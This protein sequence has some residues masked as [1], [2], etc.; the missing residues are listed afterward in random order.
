MEGFSVYPNPV[1]GV[2][3]ERKSSCNGSNQI[4]SPPRTIQIQFEIQMQILN[5]N[6]NSNT[7]LDTKR[8]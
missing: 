8:L 5:E 4:E 1:S 3:I 6:L 7:N 2:G